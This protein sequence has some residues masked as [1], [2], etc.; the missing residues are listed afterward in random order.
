MSI[1]KFKSKDGLEVLSF[2]DDFLIYESSEVVVK[3]NQIDFSIS[4]IT[5]KSDKTK[6][7][8]LR[9]AAEMYFLLKNLKGYS[10]FN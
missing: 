2:A 4:E 3:F 7:I 9:H 10:L 5:F 1:L 6:E 8:E